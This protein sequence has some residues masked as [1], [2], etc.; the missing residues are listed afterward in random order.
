MKPF[1][2]FVMIAFCAAACGQDDQQWQ[3]KDSTD[4]FSG[5]SLV[6][7]TLAGKYLDPPQ[8]GDSIAPVWIAVCEPKETHNGKDLYDGLLVKSYISFGTVVNSTT[9]GVPVVYRLDDG[10]PQAE[11]WS[12]GTAG[13]AAFMGRNTLNTILYGHSLPHRA[14]SNPPTRKLTLKVDEFQAASIVAQ[15][16]IPDPEEMAR[17]CGT[18]YHHKD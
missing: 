10:K 2:S 15:F 3:H 9:S 4:S 8:H 1:I 5:I 7:F 6:T 13:T 18:T 12:E 11:F 16:D 17:L 14:G